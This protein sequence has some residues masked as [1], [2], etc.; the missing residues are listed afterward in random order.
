MRDLASRDEDELT[1][2]RSD[3]GRSGGTVRRRPGYRTVLDE[4]DAGRVDVLYSYSLSR[5]CRSFLDFADLLK[6][7]NERGVRLRFAQE[8]DYDL[9]TATGRGFVH[10][11]RGIRA[12]GARTRR[13]A[14]RRGS[15]REAGKG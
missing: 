15:R 2:V 13:R 6:R 12:D 7:C 9:R 14:K 3:W 11:G 1:E 4:I 10:I 5:L 8:G